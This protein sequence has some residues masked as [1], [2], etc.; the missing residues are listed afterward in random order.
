MSEPSRNKTAANAQQ[1]GDFDLSDLSASKDLL[2]LGNSQTA[3]EADLSS[4]S[5]SPSTVVRV[6][7]KP[8]MRRDLVSQSS[9][10][11]TE[12]D[13]TPGLQKKKR[14]APDQPHGL[15]KN[16]VYPYSGD[17]LTRIMTF[18]ANLL[19]FL[20]RLLL[21]FFGDTPPPQIK[22][23]PQPQTLKAEAFT[24]EKNSD[25]EQE[26]SK[27]EDGLTIHRS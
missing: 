11:S 10:V 2:K 17:P 24:E 21:G 1:G 12:P 6:A 13:P 16:P 15:F 18:L 7:A 19:K 25:K 8:Q 14:G 27:E 4:A 9:S 23:Q 26:H 22:P 5:I 20:E 3:N